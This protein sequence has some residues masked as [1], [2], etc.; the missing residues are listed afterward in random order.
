M[1]P[2]QIGVVTIGGAEI[3][4]ATLAAGKPARVKTLVVD[5]TG[6][7]DVFIGTPG[8]DVNTLAKVIL[9]IPAGQS[10]SIGGIKD[11]ND[12][13]WSSFVIHGNGA[14]DIVLITGQTVS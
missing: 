6:T 5:N 13:D 11:I 10:R 14:G 9:R 2:F 12:L 4:L 8:I 7:G 3:S 1:N